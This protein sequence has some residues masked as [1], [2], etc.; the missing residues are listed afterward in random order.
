MPDL[1]VHATWTCA[2]NESWFI[3]V[4]A[5][6]PGSYHTVT[7]GRLYGREA[8]RQG[9]EYGYTCTCDGFSYRG[10]CSHAHKE[11]ARNSRCGWNGDLDPGVECARDAWGNPCCPDCGGPVTAVNVAV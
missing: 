8:E 5:S 3:N 7:F 10:T 2:S 9:Y 1:T 6:R 4:P 11:E